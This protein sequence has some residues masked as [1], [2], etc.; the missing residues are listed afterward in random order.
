M[1]RDYRDGRRRHAGEPGRFAQGTRPLPRALLYDL[2]RE[3]GKT[4]VPEIHRDGPRV[5]RLQALEPFLLAPDV[6]LVAHAALEKAAFFLGKALECLR[7]EGR[8][9]LRL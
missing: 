1:R 5:E 7:H 9:V 4:V 6:A 8:D 3:P 2:V